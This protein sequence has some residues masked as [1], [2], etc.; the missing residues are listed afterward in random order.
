LSRVKRHQRVYACLGQRMHNDEI[1][2][3][4]MSLHT[5]QEW[6]QRS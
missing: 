5:P 2:A 6:A 3:L 4:S 1:H